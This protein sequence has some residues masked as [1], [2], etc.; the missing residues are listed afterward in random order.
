MIA[1]LI[2]YA[3]TAIYYSIIDVLMGQPPWHTLSN[4]GNALLPFFAAAAAM[5]VYLV[6]RHGDLV[7]RID[8]TIQ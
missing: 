5:L 3:V 4:L 1:G 6:S 7:Q 2:G 8:E